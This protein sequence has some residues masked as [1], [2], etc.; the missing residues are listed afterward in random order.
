MYVLSNED[1][2]AYELAAEF[3]VPQVIM[4]Q[5][6]VEEQASFHLTELSYRHRPCRSN[7]F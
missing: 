1:T 2:A 7:K 4:D 6:Q 3:G 5:T